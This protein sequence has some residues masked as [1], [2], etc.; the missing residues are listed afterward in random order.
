MHVCA[1]LRRAL[2]VLWHITYLS[3]TKV[4]V[5]KPVWSVIFKASQFPSFHQAEASPWSSS[6]LESNHHTCPFLA[7]LSDVMGCA[8]L[9][10]HYHKPNVL[11]TPTRILCRQRKL[12]CLEDILSARVPFFNIVVRWNFK[13]SKAGASFAH[14]LRQRDTKS[15]RARMVF[16][17]WSSFPL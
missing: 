3:A 16:S 4:T 13:E 7:V 17:L 15:L 6:D 2:P 1:L 12:W 9:F 8:R 14:Q 11:H 10:Q 5:V